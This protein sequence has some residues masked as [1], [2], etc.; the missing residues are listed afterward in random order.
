MTYR[1]RFFI[2]AVFLCVGLTRP[3]LSSDGGALQLAADAYNKGNVLSAQS[4]AYDA[5]EQF[6]F[7]TLKPEFL[8]LLS[9][10][11]FKQKEPDQTD[12]ILK[13]L[14]S[15]FPAYARDPREKILEASLFQSRG[16][17]ERAGRI[18]VDANADEALFHAAFLLEKTGQ[19]F[20]AVSRL[21]EFLDKYKDSSLLVPARLALAHSYFSLNDFDAAKKTLEAIGTA[22]SPDVQAMRSYMAGAVAYR[23][24]QRG[25]GDR[26]MSGFSQ[27]D[28]LHRGEVLKGIYAL[29]AGDAAGAEAAFQEGLSS[30]EEVCVIRAVTGLAEVYLKAN[31]P[32]KV[33]SLC[34]SVWTSVKKDE[35]RDRL[36]LLRGV[37]HQ[38]M[39]R[40]SEAV[41]DFENVALNGTAAWKTKGL[42]LVAQSLWMSKEFTRLTQDVPVLLQ[43]MDKQGNDPNLILCALLVADADGALKH[44][45][46]AE[47]MYRD[48]LAKTPPAAVTAQT[49]SGLVACLVL[50]SKFTEAE[51]ELDQ[52]LVRFGE[53][54]DVVRFGLLSQAH[55]SWNERKYA[56]AA[57][58]YERFIQMFPSDE[59]TPMA[60][61][62]WGRSLEMSGH[63]ENALKAWADLRERFSASSYSYKALAR[64]ASLAQ[65]VG[66]KEL[67]KTLF[68]KLSG[69]DNSPTAELAL[70]Q[71]GKN[72]LES[73][74]P[75]RAIQ[76]LNGFPNR[77]PSSSHFSEV[78]E[79]MKEA[80][81]LVSLTDPKLLDQLAL[82][83]KGCDFGGEALY[84]QAIRVMEKGDLKRAAALFS[85]V[86]ADSPSVPSAP[87]AL[88]Y[89]GEALFRAG[90]YSVAVGIFKRFI[91]QY[92]SHDLAPLAR[93][94]RAAA[95]AKLGYFDEAVV[96]NQEIV[97]AS[98]QTGYASTAL[99]NMAQA[100][101]QKSD[102]P[103]EIKMYETFLQKFP[104]DAKANYACWRLGQ[105]TKRQGE[106]EASLNYFRQVQP[107]AG[108]VSKEE[109]ARVM[110]DIESLLNQ[111]GKP[112]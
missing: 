95:I 84:Y 5:L 21:R 19:S 30:K 76:T 44:Y 106:F 100:F 27:G 64:S 54:R 22:G 47:L 66:S 29:E 6:P 105:L 73:N 16:D 110:A 39:E 57:G 13:A 86:W 2:L 77:F 26:L 23:Q 7:S 4:L 102:F 20:A 101:A 3:L 24:N 15:M 79:V 50:Q 40:T 8:L 1:K 97:D 70:L 67:A 36:A 69:A 11:Y 25:E 33:V 61:Y 98:P 55:L 34:N 91:R 59:K 53:D 81:L 28:L 52:L 12:V 14:K 49:V 80:F 43:T 37:A 88:F 87:Q 10:T 9:A 68:E 17:F 60:Y 82:D 45:K 109:L 32:E 93:Q 112:K 56:E 104:K 18:L 85:T 96:A 58:R 72:A 46:E 90:D 63:S 62:Q 107:E 41:Q 65:K 35:N 78:R 42:S 103:N 94:R 48:I 51:K 75:V 74:N 92:P 89:Q 111:G 71:L 108:V 31:T 38:R 83:Y 99:L